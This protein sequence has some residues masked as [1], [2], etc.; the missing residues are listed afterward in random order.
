MKDSMIVACMLAGYAISYIL[1]FTLGLMFLD[2][3]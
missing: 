2:V 1:C 3:I